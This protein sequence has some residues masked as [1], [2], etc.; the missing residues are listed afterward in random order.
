MAK[1][2]N[3]LDLIFAAA[4]DRDGYFVAADLRAQHVSDVD[5]YRLVNRGDIERVNRGVYRIVRFPRSPHGEH[6]AAVLWA[7][8][9]VL[10]HF[11]ALRLHGLLNDRGRLIDLT[12]PSDARLRKEAPPH[13]RLH[14]A[15]LPE[16]DQAIVDGLPVTSIRRTLLDLFVG[17]E[18]GRHE[19]W[20]ATVL[21]RERGLLDE[22]T[23]E[24]IFGVIG[25]GNDLLREVERLR[26]E[27]RRSQRNERRTVHTL[28]VVNVADQRFTVVADEGRGI[29][30]VYASA[31]LDAVHPEIEHALLLLHGALRDAD[32][33]FALAQLAIATANRSHTLAIVPQIL[34]EQDIEGHALGDEMLRWTTWGWMGGEPA[35]GPG[36]ISGF[37]VL[38][39]L[40]AHLS[41][42]ARFPALRS[43]VLAGHSAGGQL[44]QRYAVVGRALEQTPGALR[45]VIAN[46][47]SYLYFDPS[48]PLPNGSFAPFDAQACPEANQ[49]KYGPENLPAYVGI[50][51]VEEL[52]RAYV[53]RGV[54][55][56]VGTLD[57]DPQHPALDR[58]CA[59]AAQGQHRY[60]RGHAYYAYLRRRHGGE[61][62]HRIADVEG[63]GH[64]SSGIF[65][66]SV[67]LDALFGE[68]PA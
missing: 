32:N 61:L 14:N 5:L 53:R 64:D 55:Y 4:V 7:A 29:V 37:S 58:S 35:V 51:T 68:H 26:A 20:Q 12:V 52:E 17:G 60:A 36:P 54:T 27:H 30:P 67:G 8:P 62:A 44:A 25:V 48:R 47:S 3:L 31:P 18:M 66:S 45:F 41:D 1:I 33:Y 24:Q 6:W 63:V 34:A 13:Y 42:R 23:A 11:T 2:S 21:A 65:T 16:R 28:P 40:I 50:R 19:L 56:L 10:S 39:G 15:Q 59:A 38:D 22:A 46:V 43:I 49:W 9:A 57:N